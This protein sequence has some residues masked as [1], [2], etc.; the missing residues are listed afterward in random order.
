MFAATKGIMGDLGAHM[1][2]EEKFNAN[3]NIEMLEQRYKV[4]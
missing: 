2:E 3:V 4:K 1:D